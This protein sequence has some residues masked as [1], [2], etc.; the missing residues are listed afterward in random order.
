[1]KFRRNN[2][3]KIIN[4]ILTYSEFETN[5][6]NNGI[7]FLLKKLGEKKK[8][9]KERKLKENWCKGRVG[10]TEKNKPPES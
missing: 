7:L 10:I 2:V 6:Y 5:L 1:M 9:F 3:Y 8:R 4:F